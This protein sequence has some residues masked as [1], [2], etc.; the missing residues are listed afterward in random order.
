VSYIVRQTLTMLV[1]REYLAHYPR[2]E[3]NHDQ[4]IPEPKL[5]NLWAEMQK[6]K[7]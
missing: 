7:D 6:A 4:Y 5:L 2:A 3:R 1:D